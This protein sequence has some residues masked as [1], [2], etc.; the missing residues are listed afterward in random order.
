MLGIVPDAPRERDWTDGPAR[1]VAVIVLGAASIAGMAWSMWRSSPSRAPG[2]ALNPVAAP[3]A[4]PR[5]SPLPDRPVAKRV[6]INTA[7]AAE[8]ELLPGVGPTVALRIIEQRQTNGPFKRVEDLDQVRGIGAR[9]LEKLR[10]LV[11]VE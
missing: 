1:W 2:V 11:T 3:A 9:T 8:L 4:E 7:T 6:N 5:I 10:D